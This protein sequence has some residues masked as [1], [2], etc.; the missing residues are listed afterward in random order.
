MLI[1]ST[2]IVGGIF[3]KRK[4]ILNE[5]FRKIESLPCF[6][7]DQTAVVM[8]WLIHE[9]LQKVMNYII[10]IVDIFDKTNHP[11]NPTGYSRRY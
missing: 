10:V 9:L 11:I 6:K 2:T 5:R 4:S 8:G 3:C 7:S 1:S